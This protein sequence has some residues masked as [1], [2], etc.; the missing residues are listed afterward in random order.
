MV[1]SG[2]AGRNARSAISRKGVTTMAEPTGAMTFEDLVLEVA[3][4]LGSA[5]YG[6]NGDEAPQIPLPG[7]DLDEAKGIVNKAIRIFL[8]DAPA[9]NGWRFTKPTADVVVWPS[10]AVNAN[11]TV[12]S[13]GYDPGTGKTTLTATADSFYETMEERT[14]TITGIGDFTISDYISATQVRVVGDA[15]ATSAATWSITSTGAYTLPRTFGG[16]HSGAITYSAGAAVGVNIEWV[17]ESA[18]RQWRES[19]DDETGDPFWAAIRPM[20]TGTPRRR[21]ELLVYPGPSAVDRIEIHGLRGDVIFSDFLSTTILEVGPD[22]KSHQHTGRAIVIPNSYFLQHRTINESFL[23]DYVLHIFSIPINIKS[24]IEIAKKCLEKITQ[25]VS[26]P[27]LESATLHIHNLQKKRSVE[28]PDPKPRVFISYIDSENIEFII[29][30][31]VPFKKKGELEQKIITDFI[32]TK[33][34]WLTRA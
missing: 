11:V 22:M 12:T 34:L 17:Q 31:S 23:K 16:A 10:I 33:N 19:G 9:P 26:A 28:T 14:L 4:K 7:H 32:K 20:A 15:S 6:E 3:L 18:I 27:Y 24:K 13:A 21:W 8:A 1:C 30:I 2:G 25:K 5:Y 29:R